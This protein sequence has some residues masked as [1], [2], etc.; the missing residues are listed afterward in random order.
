MHE[1]NHRGAIWKDYIPTRDSVHVAR[2][3]KAGCIVIGKTAAPTL[4]FTGWTFSK[5]F[6]ITRNPWNLERTP[7]GSSGGTSAAIAARILPLSTASDGGG[8]IRG[9]SCYVGAFG[10]KPTYGRIPLTGK[11]PW[12]GHKHL[13]DFAHL[14]PI[15]RNVLDA[16]I[17]IDACAGYHPDD[18]QSLPK[19]TISYEAVVRNPPTKRLK[20]A[21]SRTLGIV[22]GVQPEVMKGVENAVE[23]LRSL[24][25][26]VV[27]L[28]DAVIPKPGIGWTYGAGGN[29]WISV[30]QEIAGKES[31][32]DESFVQGVE[33]AGSITIKDIAVTL[34]R[35]SEINEALNKHFFNPRE[36]DPQAGYDVLVS[37][38]MPWEAPAALP[39]LPDEVG[40]AKLTMGPGGNVL[41]F[42]GYSMVGWL[43]ALLG[44]NRIRQV[45]PA[46]SFANSRST[47]AGTLRVSFARDF[48]TPG[49]RP[50]SSLSDGSTRTRCCLRWRQSMR[51]RR[52]VLTSGRKLKYK[53]EH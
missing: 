46:F 30:G 39:S 31:E 38:G 34:R 7:G 2:L 19:P 18:F 14:G 50:V 51:R 49:Y 53:W 45:S 29:T 16:A 25:H 15:T 4:G 23:T 47:F 41:D 32:L 1:S 40:G 13:I 8:S 48:R 10:F 36:D 44:L 37:P 27:E 22:P 9:P 3:K 52:G 42:W 12:P 35:I 6:G 20:I 33:A 5:S 11:S 21:F 24:G 17:Y 26:T 43:V 28:D